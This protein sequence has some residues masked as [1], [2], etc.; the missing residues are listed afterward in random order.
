MAEAITGIHTS[1]TSTPRGFVNVVFTEYEP[2]SFFTAGKPNTVS[3]IG[4]KIRAGRDR[5]SRAELLTRLSEAWTAITGQIGAVCWSDSTS[6][7]RRPS[8][9]PA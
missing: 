9:K 2:M 8:W 4:G 6:S 7:T 3:V 5:A 1:V